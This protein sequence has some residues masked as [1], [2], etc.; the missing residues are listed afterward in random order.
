MYAGKVNYSH[1]MGYAD[2]ITMS[3]YTEDGSLFSSVVAQNSTDW[4]TTC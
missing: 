2:S 1:S 3:A 4:Q